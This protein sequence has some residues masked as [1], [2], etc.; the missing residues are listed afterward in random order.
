MKDPIACGVS[1]SL[2]CLMP[3][4]RQ[5]STMNGELA[6]LVALCLYGNDW[7]ATGAGPVPA[8]ES[9]NSAF[10]YV[11]SFHSQCPERGLLRE[12]TWGGE[13]SAAWLRHIRG[14]GSRRLS[15]LVGDGAAPHGI[16]DHVAASFANSGRWAIVSDGPRPRIWCS[17]WSVRNQDDP[18][19]RIW[20]VEMT[21]QPLSAEIKPGVDLPSAQ[22]H[23]RDALGAIA[24]FA[25]SE[26]LPFWADWFAT[27]HGLLDE[28][29]PVIPYHP[30][31]APSTTSLDRR[32]L[33]AAAVQ[34]WVFGGMGSWNDLWF[35][36]DERNKAYAELTERLYAAVLTAT[37]AAVNAGSR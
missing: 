28:S 31:L 24:S 22:V 21:G 34:A 15:L 18:N 23:L 36:N 11:S 3:Q 25:E 12:R 1:P 2:R 8:L 32:R 10:Q 30:D 9:D 16:P 7:L 37:A 29:E 35:D 6:S 20:G 13:G 33:L 5:N 4:T 17:V 27:A 14:G 26:D 19:R